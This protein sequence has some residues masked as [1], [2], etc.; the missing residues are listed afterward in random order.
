MSPNLQYHLNENICIAESAFRPG[1]D[2]H[3]SLLTEARFYFENGVTF[4]SITEELFIK[5][6]LGFIGEYLGEPVPLDFPIEELNEAEYKGREVDL[7]YPK[8]GGA[9][10]YHVYVK[11]P[12]P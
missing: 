4:D 5:T 12:S 1:S 7:N 10:K 2:A 3:I 8:R 11:N 6:D 9:K